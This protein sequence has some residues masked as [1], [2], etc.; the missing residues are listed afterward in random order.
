MLPNMSHPGSQFSDRPR[1]PLPDGPSV[2]PVADGCA[3]CLPARPVPGSR[4]LV[5][6]WTGLALL[7]PVGAAQAQIIDWELGFSVQGVYDDNLLRLSDEE[8]PDPGESESDFVHEYGVNGEVGLNISRQRLFLAGNAVIRRHIENTQLDTTPFSFTGGWQWAVYR[9][10]GE[11][12]GVFREVTSEIDQLDGAELNTERTFGVEQ[13][14]TC[15]FGSEFSAGV[16]SSYRET[17]NSLDTEEA[18]DRQRFSVDGFVG[19]DV[20]DLMS[21]E[22]GTSF[23]RTEFPNRDAGGTL[24]T[25]INQ[26]GFDLRLSR[27]FSPTFQ[28]GG[29]VGA[30]V[31]DGVGDSGPFPRFAIDVGWRVTPKVSLT[32]TGGRTIDSPQ[33]V[34]SALETNDVIELAADWEFTPKIDFGSALSFAR[35]SFETAA[36]EGSLSEDRED[37]RFSSEVSVGY[38]PIDDLR[39]S[40][41]Y[42]FVDQDSTVDTSSFQSQRVSFRAAYQF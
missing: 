3:G 2:A 39:L 18:D 8:E 10:D 37:R 17:V 26:V 38:R 11:L 4:W 28:L 19:Y 36:A 21:V 1:C 16:N 14:A 6:A 41:A 35:S 33:T 7:M 34:D 29:S 32:L 13:S 31:I 12:S 22:F 20:P 15:L 42:E 40:L 30:T 27:E 5:G 9:C 23:Q 24:P 25:D